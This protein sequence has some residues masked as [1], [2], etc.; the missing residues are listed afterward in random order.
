MK[1]NRK[2]YA[3]RRMSLAIDRVIAKRGDVEK[4]RL[5]VNAWAIVAGLKRI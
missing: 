4:A 2:L 1:K 3:G 5:W